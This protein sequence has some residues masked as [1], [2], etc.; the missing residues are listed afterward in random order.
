MPPLSFTDS[1]LDQV[2]A[3][4]CGRITNG[5]VASAN[6]VYLLGKRGTRS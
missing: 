6:P 5:V 4:R 1:Q 3:V 2:L